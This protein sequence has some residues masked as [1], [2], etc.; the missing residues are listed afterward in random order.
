[1]IVFLH[2]PKTAGST[3]QFILE[4]SFGISACHTNHTKKER[5]T[6]SDFESGPGN[7]S[8][9]R[10]LAGQA[11]ELLLAFTKLSVDR[12]SLRSAGFL[13][14]SSSLTSISFS[15]SKFPAK[16]RTR[17]TARINRN[18]RF[19]TPAL[20]AALRGLVPYRKIRDKARG[21]GKSIRSCKNSASS[22]RALTRKK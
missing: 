4:N 1:M 17:T 3:F 21:G 10:S 12:V 13:P 9:L 18:Q 19:S 7:F 14:P 2:I 6:R 5:F 15:S 20:I 11:R 16:S 8:R 22:S